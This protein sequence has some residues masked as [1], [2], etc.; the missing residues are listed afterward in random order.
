[1]KVYRVVGFA[2]G[3]LFMSYIV[4]KKI[5][6]NELWFLVGYLIAA[7]LYYSIEAKMK[8]RPVKKEV[9]VNRAARRHPNGQTP[10]QKFKTVN[11]KGRQKQ[12]RGKAVRG[13]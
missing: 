8:D 3:F 7:V 9:P 6:T 4:D 12:G 5:S 13:W 10:A 11:A 2:I 1:M